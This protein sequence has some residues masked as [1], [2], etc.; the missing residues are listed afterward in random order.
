MG[1]N[2]LQ[3]ISQAQITPEMDRFATNVAKWLTEADERFGIRM[4]D[5]HYFMLSPLRYNEV[6]QEHIKGP[7]H[8]Y[9]W[10][11]MLIHL[12]LQPKENSLD[13][14]G[15]QA[16]ADWE[17]L[18][19][20]PYCTI[21]L[22]TD[23]PSKHHP[24]IIKENVLHELV[25]CMDPKLTNKK[26]QEEEWHKRHRK[27]IGQ[28]SYL[29][30]EEYYTSPWEQDAFMASHA[31]E[32]MQMWKRNDVSKH[33]IIDELRNYLPH[34]NFERAYY[35]NKDIWKRYLSY[36]YKVLQQVYGDDELAT[37]DI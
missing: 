14:R 2:W 4:E 35:K 19:G 3:K 27:S 25:H 12:I 36:L 13:G 34:E 20:N 23:I 9:P 21:T 1:L 7:G 32:K 28:P 37:E 29:G 30:S 16:K 17:Q 24:G 22:F 5:G 26:L 18:S 31:L 15:G 10:D 11:A 33:R 8:E 6:Y